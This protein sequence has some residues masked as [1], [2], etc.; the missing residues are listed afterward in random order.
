MYY[1]A[2]WKTALRLLIIRGILDFCEVM[3]VRV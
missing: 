2:C 3:V 1:T